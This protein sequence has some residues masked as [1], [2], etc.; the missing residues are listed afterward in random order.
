M[1]PM[2]NEMVCVFH[3]DILKLSMVDILSKGLNLVLKTYFRRNFEDA[4]TLI[5]TILK[6]ISCKSPK[7]DGFILSPTYITFHFYNFFTIFSEIL[8][9]YQK[10]IA[11]CGKFIY[12][13]SGNTSYVLNSILFLFTVVVLNP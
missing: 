1:N 4:L 12:F 10:F 5:V 3:S 6:Y 11:G 2:L 9:I 13:F 7:R 8:G